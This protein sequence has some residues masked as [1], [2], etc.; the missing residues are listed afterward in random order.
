MNAYRVRGA[1]PADVPTLVRLLGMLFSLEAD[2]S[3]EPE[4]QRRGLQAL[5]AAPARGRV[6]VAEQGGGVVGMCSLQRLVSTAAGG[7]VGVIE[8]VIVL[9]E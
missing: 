8:D 9:P 7:E 5:L 1:R 3:V 2:F 6:L 4:R